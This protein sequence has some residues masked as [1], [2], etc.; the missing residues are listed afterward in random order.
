LRLA[1]RFPAY[2]G[3]RDENQTPEGAADRAWRLEQLDSLKKVRVSSGLVQ[4]V[5]SN[6]ST[7]GGATWN[8]DDVIVFAAGPDGLSRV[9]ARGGPVS[10]VTTTDEGS[11][12]WP[13]FL[14]DGEH[15]IYAAAI[16]GR[17]YLGSLGNVAPR[18]LMKFPG[19]ISYLARAETAAQARVAFR[20]TF[21]I[22]SIRIDPENRNDL[23]VQRL[24]AVDE[25]L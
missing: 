24:Q 5:A 23:W 21:P 1:G 16:P 8:A 22:V 15:F 2:A 3:I 25:R 19:R 20:S 6:V 12:F 14:G 17:I 18:I 4:P 7:S 9:S 10:T 11:H 13:Q